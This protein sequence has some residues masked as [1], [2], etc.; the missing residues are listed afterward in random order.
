ML[1]VFMVVV[2]IILAISAYPFIARFLLLAS[3]DEE[4][5]NYALDFEDL[6]K[7]GKMGNRWSGWK[8]KD[9]V[10]GKVITESST[11]K[12]TIGK[13]KPMPTPSKVTFKRSDQKSKYTDMYT[14]SGGES[15]LD[16][17]NR[18]LRELRLQGKFLKLDDANIGYLQQ[19]TAHD[20]SQWKDRLAEK[21]QF[22]DKM[23]EYFM[24]EVERLQK[25]I[26]M[27]NDAMNKP[28]VNVDP[29]Y[30][31]AWDAKVQEARQFLAWVG[32]QR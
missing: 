31:K 26:G 12:S 5:R 15:H 30:Q 20:P 25:R 16:R 8:D 23:T 19:L 13:S 17:V 24:H 11:S 4:Q 2:A 3:M 10:E 21:K 14:L 9:T 27:G 29:A 6:H 7:T 28:G 1:T 32:K 22:T 18:T